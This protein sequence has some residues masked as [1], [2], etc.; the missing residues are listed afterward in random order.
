MVSDST[1]QETLTG[2]TAVLVRPRDKVR[3]AVQLHVRGGE[4]SGAV[5]EIETAGYGELAA[6]IY[7]GDKHT[8]GELHEL[9]LRQHHSPYARRYEIRGN[10]QWLQ[11][12]A[13]TFKVHVTDTLGNQRFTLVE[14]V[15]TE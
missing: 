8:A 12:G 15:D 5:A 1:S 3:P 10:H 13:H 14:H 9:K 2:H 4:I 7:W 6:Q 11:T